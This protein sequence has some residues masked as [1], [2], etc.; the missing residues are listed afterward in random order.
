MESLQEMAALP[1]NTF[2]RCQDVSIPIGLPIRI[3][4]DIIVFLIDRQID[5][6][7]DRQIDRQSNR[8][9]DSRRTSPL[10]LDGSVRCEFTLTHL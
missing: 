4:V 5:R 9:I 6:Q 7:S 8:Q 1:Q 2:S 10:H 3:P